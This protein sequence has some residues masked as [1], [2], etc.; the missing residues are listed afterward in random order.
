MN[1]KKHYPYERI[2]DLQLNGFTYRSLYVGLGNQKRIIQSA[3]STISS[4]IMNLPHQFGN[5]SSF[6]PGD[7]LSQHGDSQQ[8]L[9]TPRENIEDPGLCI[10]ELAPEI[11]LKEN[12]QFFDI[13]SFVF[14]YLKL[15][16]ED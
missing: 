10:L 7:E 1:M 16:S 11:D 3:S 8:A 4:L 13:P 2:I 6:L 5:L 9:F 15:G 14:K 12:H